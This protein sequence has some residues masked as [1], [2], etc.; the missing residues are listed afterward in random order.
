M[1]PDKG[2]DLE[3]KGLKLDDFRIFLEYL[4]QNK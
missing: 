2:Y 4:Y 3:I 1:L